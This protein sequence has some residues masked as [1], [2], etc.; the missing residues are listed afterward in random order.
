[1]LSRDRAKLVAFLCLALIFCASN[2]SCLPFRHSDRHA[3]YDVPREQ[4][5]MTLPPYVIEPPDVLL[6]DAVRLVPLPPYKLEPLDALLVQFPADPGSLPVADLEALT[7]T[8]RAFSGVIPVDPEGTVNLGAAFGAVRVADMTIDEARKA[9]DRRLRQVLKS[10]LVDLGKVSVD[11][12]QIRGLQQ[13]RGEHLVRPDGTV[14]LGTY[15]SVYVTGMTLDQAKAQIEAHL[16]QFILKPS[17][18]LDVAGFNSK[19]Y[20][21]IFDG[22]GFG[23]QVFRL[24][25][26]GNETVLDAISNVRGLPVVASRHRIWLA[27]PGHGNEDG[28]TILPVDWKAITRHGSSAKN[29]QVFPGDRIYVA[30]QPLI[31]ADTYLG[32]LI[33]PIERILGVTLLT[34]S[35]ITSVNEIRNSSNIGINNGVIR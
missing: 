8:G 4:E 24:P 26:T 22:A 33:S 29:Y 20:Y 5:K 9:I 6:I 11:L 17:I 13:V 12:A 32:R 15:G 2:T 25:V 28:E 34:S 23:E 19:V 3:F 27:R 35:T 16:S 7:K 31:S 10:E 1:M 21:V 18:S 30:A 14:G